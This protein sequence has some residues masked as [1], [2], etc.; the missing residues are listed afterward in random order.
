MTNDRNPSNI[1]TV[2]DLHGEQ[3]NHKHQ[4]CSVCARLLGALCVRQLIARRLMIIDA[5]VHISPFGENAYD[6][7]I[8]ELLRRRDR[9]GVDKALT[10]L[11][12]PYMT[13][14]MSA[15]PIVMF[16]GP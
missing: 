14:A 13:C 4:Y 15:Q 10:W 2:I 16:L 8:D 11:R 7:T 3:E 12:P 9:A 5:D 1:V 6:I